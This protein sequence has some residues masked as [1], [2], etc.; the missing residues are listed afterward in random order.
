MLTGKRIVVTGASSGIGKSVAKLLSQKGAHIIALSRSTPTLPGVEHHKTDLRN[1]EQIAKSFKKIGP[2][3][4]L[5]N[6]AGMAYSSSLMSGPLD[7]WN[8]MWEV[9]VRAL[10]YASQ[11]ALQAFPNSEGQIINISSMSG[12]RVPPS[13]GFYAPTKFAVRAL[14]ES[15][16]LELRS[17]SNST[18][19]SSISPG[20]VD[21]PLLDTYFKGKEEQLTQTKESIKMLTPE[22]IANQVLNILKTPLHVEVGDIAMRSVSQ[23]I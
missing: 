10:A 18:R 2:F 6:N 17:A 15:L 12:H 14:T 16:R 7:E 8:E 13:G 5:I 22:D 19:V 23:T 3:D 20:F 4:I 11:L 21:T 1:P 9:N